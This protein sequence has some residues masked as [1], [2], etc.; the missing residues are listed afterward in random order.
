MA[1][2]TLVLVTHSQKMLEV[3]CD[4]VTL[5]GG[6]G[7]MGVLPGHTGLISTVIPG[8]LSYRDG[9][10]EHRFAVSSGFCE[11]SG[12]VLTV[13]VDRAQKAEEIDI[14]QARQDVEA[15]TAALGQA[16]AELDEVAKLQERLA[17]AE[18]RLQVAGGD[19]GH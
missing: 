14:D 12:D 19:G 16:G 10:S 18:A 1:K 3:E 11:M 8:L 17:D 6:E 7:E 13:L 5:P 15:A 2:V 4:E 9:G